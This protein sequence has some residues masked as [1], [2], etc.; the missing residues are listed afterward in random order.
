[1]KFE[2]YHFCLS[3]RQIVKVLFLKDVF[4]QIQILRGRGGRR[5]ILLKFDTHSE[6]SGTACHSHSLVSELLHSSTAKLGVQTQESQF[7]ATCLQD[8]F[9]HCAVSCFTWSC[10]LGSKVVLGS[11]RQGRLADLRHFLWNIQCNDTFRQ[12]VCMLKSKKPFSKILPVLQGQPVVYFQYIKW[13]LVLKPPTF[14][15]LKHSFNF[16]A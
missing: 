7:A 1:M 2:F 15:N 3:L 8:C 16:W 12:I 13:D 5:I 11:Q 6:N 10:A 14:I 4:I 9:V